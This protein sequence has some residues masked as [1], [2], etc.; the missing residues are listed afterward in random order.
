MQSACL[1]LPGSRV[2]DATTIVY[3]RGARQDTIAVKLPAPP[4]IVFASM[5]KL[6]DENPELVATSINEAATLL[7]VRKNG[8]ELT[9]QATDLG[10]GQSL[11][12]IWIDTGKT[13][14][15]AEDVGLE[16]ARTIC[17]DLGVE[18]VI[19]RR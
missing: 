11:L 4:D 18:F 2:T 16:A 12:F 5:R 14:L 13:G 6:V 19:V 17:D 7:E 9:G 3:A 15:S 1:G 10:G 8:L